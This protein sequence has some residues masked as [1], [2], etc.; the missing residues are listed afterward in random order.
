MSGGGNCVLV[1]PFYKAEYDG[2]FMVEGVIKV[3]S[4]AVAASKNKI[5]LSADSFQIRDS[6]F[7]V[8]SNITAVQSAKSAYLGACS[9]I[10][11]IK[12][13]LLAD[14]ERIGQMGDEFAAV[15]ERIASLLAN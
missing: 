15:D 8:R 6:D 3:S 11:Q 12:E 4:E 5:R 9:S 14:A 1:L 13:I 7:S 10:A 2:A